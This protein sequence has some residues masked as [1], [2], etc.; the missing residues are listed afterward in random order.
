MNPVCYTPWTLGKFF[1]FAQGLPVDCVGA[2]QS[3]AYFPATSVQHYLLLLG[4][5]CFLELPFYLLALR[6]KKFVW[7]L[8]ACNV[9]THPC[10]YFLFPALA[11]KVGANYGQTLFASEL[12][13]IVAEAL[14]L[15]WV[16]KVSPSRA[17]VCSVLANLFSWWVGVFILNWP[18]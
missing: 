16:W 13:A 9:L 5:T 12:F 14:L 8:L 2:L 18:L 10:V 17:L 3:P 11:G 7:P 6:S 15:A 1:L 4:W